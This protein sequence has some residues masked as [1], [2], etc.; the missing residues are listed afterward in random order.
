[1]FN[2][3]SS[4]ELGSTEYNGLPRAVPPEALLGA[5]KCLD[6]AQSRDDR[7]DSALFCIGTI[8]STLIGEHARIVSHTVRRRM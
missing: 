8:Y 6:G 2:K 7:V 3:L 5:R 1:M 4:H